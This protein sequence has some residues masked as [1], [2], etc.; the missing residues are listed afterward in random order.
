MAAGSGMSF[1]FLPGYYQRFNPQDE[2][3]ILPILMHG[4]IWSAI[5]A[6]GGLAF[7][8]GMG[9][10]ART[11]RALLGGLLGAVAA[12][13]LYE[14]VGAVLLPLAKTSQPLAATSGARLLAQLL[15]A[16]FVAA[17]AAA[18][19]GAASGIQ[20]PAIEPNHA[21]SAT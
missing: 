19:A 16:V 14:V 7:G 13:L 1:L 5:G 10:A 21:S 2:D 12:T 15:V 20:K 3:L 8:I 11:F 17:F 18:G 6:G 4:G 9:G